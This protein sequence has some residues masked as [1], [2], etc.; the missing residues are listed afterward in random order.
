MKTFNE[1]FLS[2][3]KERQD[4]LK[5][6]KWMLAENAY[7]AGQNSNKESVPNDDF[8]TFG[9]ILDNGEY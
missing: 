8:S 3:P 5:E 1:W 4:I 6:D 7:K 2:L 9:Y